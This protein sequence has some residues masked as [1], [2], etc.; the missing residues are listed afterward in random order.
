MCAMTDGALVG[1]RV[2]LRA[3]R[4]E[5]RPRLREILEEGDVARW[6]GQVPPDELLDGLYDVSEQVTFV[7][8]VDGVVVGSIQ[9]AEEDD[10][11]YR[12]AGIDIFLDAEH[13]GYGLGRDAV[14][15]LARYLFDVRGHHRLTI[16][17]AFANERAIRSYR[18]VGFKPIGVMRA[19]ERG[20]DGSFHDSLL[21]DMLRGELT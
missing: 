11:V 8:E 19:Y 9:Y 4:P 1:E 16:D 20:P 2:E 5:D 21:L 13:Q 7:V 14:R 18:S 6:W 10:P 17:P 3:I 15:T 12:H